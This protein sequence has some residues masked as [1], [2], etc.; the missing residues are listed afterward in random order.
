MDFKTTNIKEV[1]IV[2]ETNQD[3]ITLIMENGDQFIVDGKFIKMGPKMKECFGYDWPA[4]MY[5][6]RRNIE[7]CVWLKILYDYRDDPENLR[8][9]KD[10]E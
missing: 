5:Y 9:D 7:P 6:I 1:L 3:A 8:M 2:T 4:F 10:G